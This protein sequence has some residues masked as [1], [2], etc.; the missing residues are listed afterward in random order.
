MSE[1][2]EHFFKESDRIANKDK[3]PPREVADIDRFV[4]RKRVSNFPLQAVLDNVPIKKNAKRILEDY[5]SLRVL[6]KVSRYYCPKHQNKPR[7]LEVSQRLSKTGY[8]QKCDATYLLS[9]LE[10]ETIYERIKL[11]SKWSD[12]AEEPSVKHSQTELDTESARSKTLDRACNIIKY[13]LERAYKLAVDHLIKLALSAL[14]V[15]GGVSF[16]SCR[17]TGPTPD[18]AATESDIFESTPFRTPSDIP[19]QPTQYSA[20]MEDTAVSP[21][22]K[23]TAE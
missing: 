4:A 1:M 5:V 3:Y 17:S 21:P 9:G 15:G 8:C 19:T 6:K 20:V 7:V 16:H 14:L 2:S 13:P 23:P 12:S 22:P 11:P 18:V 10:T